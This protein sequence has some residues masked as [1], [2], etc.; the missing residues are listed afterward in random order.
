[1]PCT[2]TGG[3]NIKPHDYCDHNQHLE[4]R[5]FDK[6]LYLAGQVRKLNEKNESPGQAE[7]DDFPLNLAARGANDDR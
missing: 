7:V 4:S 2:I 3:A 1:V 5:D 6:Q